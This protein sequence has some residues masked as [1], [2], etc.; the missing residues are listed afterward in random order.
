MGLIMAN[1]YNGAL[2][3]SPFASQHLIIQLAAGIVFAVIIL[4]VIS[5]MLYRINFDY[6]K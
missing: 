2:L 5:W 1:A 6:L 4:I 3:S